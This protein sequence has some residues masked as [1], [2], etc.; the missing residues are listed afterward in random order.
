MHATCYLI[1]CIANIKNTKIWSNF[2]PLLLSAGTI[3]VN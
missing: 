1:T 2:I 3:R